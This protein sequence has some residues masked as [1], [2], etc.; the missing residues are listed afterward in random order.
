M[1][2]ALE[3]KRSRRRLS[4]K[5]GL[6]IIS[7]ALAG[8][9]VAGGGAAYF[10]LQKSL[11]QVSGNTAIEG[12]TSEVNVYRDNNGVPHIEADSMKDLFM[13]QGYVTAQDRLFQMDLSRR[14]ASGMLSEVIGEKTLDRDRFFR[15]LGLRRAAVASYEE[16]SDDT[17]QYLQWYADG[18]NA[19]IKE[20]MNE[21]MLP[22]EF[23]LIGYEPK[24]WTPIDS[25]V[26]GKYMAFDL[27]GHWEGQAFRYYL[28]ENFT[29]EKALDLFPG[30]PDGA[31][32]ILEDI[33]SSGIDFEKSFADAV[34]P[35][36]HNGS[37][38]W[39]VSG[40][41]T[42]SGKPMLANDPH[43]QLGTPSIW[44]QTH[45]KGPDYEVSGVIFAGIPGIIVGHNDSIAWGVTNVGPDVQELYIEKRN[46]ENPYEFQYKEKWDKATVLNEV[47][48]VKDGKDVKHEVVIT[49]H[50]PV[51]SEFAHNDKPGT[52][53]ALKWTALRPSKEL[54]AVIQMNRSKNWEQFEE[55]LQSFHTPAQ[56]FVFAS[57]DGTIA[58]KANGLIPI[59][60]QD[61]TSLPVPGWTDEYE[62]EGYIPWNRLPSVVN[63]SNGFV[64][65]ANN[66]VTGDDYPYHITDTFAQPYRQQ[67]ITEVLQS[68]KKLTVEDMQ[69]LQ[70]DQKN[71]QAEE[72]LPILLE[73]ME[74]K[75]LNEKEKNAAAILKKWNLK[76]SKDSAAPLI[77]HFWMDSF[78]Q[79]LFKDEISEEMMEMFDGREQVVDELIRAAY[80]GNPGPW[81]K[82]RDGL[83]KVTQQS[84][85][86][87][88]QELS[89]KYG[90]EMSG[91]KW[92][93]YHTLTFEHPLAAIKPLDLLF[94]P[95]SEEMGGSR[96]TVGVAGFNRE[97]GH[98][99][100]GGAWR[101]VI[102][103]A[104]T[105]KAYHV[106][107][108]GQSGHVLS[109]WYSDQS[110][111]WANGRYHVTYLTEKDYRQED[112]HL[113]LSPPAAEKK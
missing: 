70:F 77:F 78:S 69:S 79:V 90:E 93:T 10:L 88:L 95:Q 87:A 21:N 4:W 27:G 46:P 102:D 110:A 111:D 108:P 61:Y 41:K 66:K 19:Y 30:Y 8:L 22:V 16:Y 26:I 65:T 39:V 32:A 5:K 105:E 99:T 75:P 6:L 101:M 112:K 96:V 86:I 52:A 23:F 48:K 13:A 53:L 51:L 50:G 36:Y 63:P 113:V 94:N 34:I 84:F 42:A 49:R 64:A 54:E 58:Y 33:K 47:I 7:V 82:Q 1:E 60:K 80:S 37:N 31:P 55:A 29:K 100:H 57:T 38:N 97:T 92:G 73:Q 109:Q 11:P 91:W 17:K 56:N 40:T 106:V 81:I 3:K 12:L 72:M 45:L 62:W 71:K 20:A 83:E 59:R 104:D 9:L 68:E 2:G 43:L 107:G 76:D 25:L 28:M 14:Q 35:N 89:E 74:H 18:V 44:Y 24:K 103:M 15:T 85:A 98:V 67:R